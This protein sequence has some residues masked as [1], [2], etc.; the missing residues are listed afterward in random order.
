MG[1]AARQR[2]H[3]QIVRVGGVDA[4]LL[5]RGDPVQ[6]QL[7]LAVRLPAQ[8]GL[9]RLGVDGGL[10]DT[11]AFAEIQHPAMVLV[12][13]L[14]AGQGAPWDQFM[15]VGIAGVVADFLR[16]EA[17]PGRRGDDLARLGL[18]VAETDLV[19]F[20]ADG[21]MG[22]IEAGDLGQRIPGLDGH[23]TIGLRREGKDHF[24]GIDGG[25]ERG[26]ALGHAFLLHCLGETGQLMHFVLGVPVD[27]LAAVA[28]LVEQRAD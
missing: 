4:P 22:V 25:V 2:E 15:H 21:E 19:V 17:G 10:V 27:A 11:G 18:H 5:V 8:H 13:L 7:V 28:E 6:H 3:A 26:A 9:D 16:F 1:A 23:M 14:A 20:A 24:T 12:E